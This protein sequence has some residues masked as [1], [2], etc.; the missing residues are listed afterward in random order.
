MCATRGVS[1]RCGCRRAG[2]GKGPGREGGCCSASAS[3]RPH[4]IR[5]DIH[6]R[7]RVS[8]PGPGQPVRGRPCHRHHAS[9][10]II[11]GWPQEW[12]GLEFQQC[13]CCDTSVATSVHRRAAP[14]R[15]EEEPSELTFRPAPM[16][17]LLPEPAGQEPP[18]G[19]ESALPA[20]GHSWGVHPPGS[21]LRSWFK[22]S[23]VSA[24]LG[25]PLICS[26]L[27]CSHLQEGL[28]RHFRLAL[29]RRH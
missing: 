27:H 13:L 24:A 6:R 7:G 17:N 12:P 18:K 16:G 3:P 5:P 21:K 1:N 19:L 11:F 14:H 10:H 22:P 2:S 29:A 20:Q 28:S 9:W 23:S 4:Q 25:S 26:A 15:P 8:E